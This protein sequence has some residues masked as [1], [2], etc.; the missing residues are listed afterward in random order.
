MVRK[1]TMWMEYRMFPSVC[2]ER[3]ILSVYVDLPVRSIEIYYAIIQHKLRSNTKKITSF[4]LIYINEFYNIII[5]KHSSPPTCLTVPCYANPSKPTPLS[6]DVI[7]YINTILNEM[8]LLKSHIDLI[9]AWLVKP[10]QIK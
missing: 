8:L 1:K 5:T 9:R 4:H 2:R 3:I 10:F 7:I 6:R